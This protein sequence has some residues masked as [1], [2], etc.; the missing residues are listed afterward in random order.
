MK[1]NEN[2]FTLVVIHP[3]SC[4]KHQTQKNSMH[5]LF[6]NNIFRGC[7]GCWWRLIPLCFRQRFDETNENCG[8]RAK[9]ALKYFIFSIHASP[10]MRMCFYVYYYYV[11]HENCSL[12]KRNA[13]DRLSVA[14]KYSYMW[15]VSTGSVENA[16]CCYRSKNSSLQLFAA[17]KKCFYLLECVDRDLSRAMTAKT[18]S[19]V[20]F[21]RLY[22]VIVVIIV[23]VDYLLFLAFDCNYVIRMI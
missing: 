9:N 2:L 16:H 14:V 11:S 22:I 17:G 12:E 7:C 19:S 3:A 10:R 8:D 5:K 15:V 21:F 6:F 1:D 20:H 13:L 4:L 23:V 18:R